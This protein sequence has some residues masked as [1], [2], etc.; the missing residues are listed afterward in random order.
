MTNPVIIAMEA[1]KNEISIETLT[2]EQE[3]SA[4]GSKLQKN[5]ID[6]IWS[7]EEEREKVSHDDEGRK[8]PT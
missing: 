2:S 1:A 6:S 3:S 4:K 5:M 7:K 8:P